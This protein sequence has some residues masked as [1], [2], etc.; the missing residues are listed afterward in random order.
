MVL[1]QVGIVLTQ[2]LIVHGTIGLLE[3]EGLK[4]RQVDFEFVVV[5]AALVVLVEAH[6]TFL[7]REFG[8]FSG[9]D[10]ALSVRYQVPVLIDLVVPRPP[11]DFIIRKLHALVVVGRVRHDFSTAQIELKRGFV[12]WR[13][14][15]GIS[16]DF[17]VGHV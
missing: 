15:G 16:L 14:D 7:E 3:R 2:P 8:A 1:I 11:L 4:L 5:A 17:E 13:N 6:G 12:I 9:S 10:G